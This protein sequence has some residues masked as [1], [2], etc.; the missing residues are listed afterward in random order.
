LGGYSH[1]RVC[2]VVSEECWNHFGYLE[3]IGKKLLMASNRYK[4]KPQKTSKFVFELL[5]EHPSVRS[6]FE[7]MRRRN[8][9]AEEARAELISS[10]LGC[11]WEMEKGLPNRWPQIVNGLSEGRSSKELV[12]EY[13]AEQSGDALF[14]KPH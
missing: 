14:P 9:P 8:I 13:F 6:A 3:H 7:A 5:G 1:R 10:F 4:C 12:P 11:L 2:G